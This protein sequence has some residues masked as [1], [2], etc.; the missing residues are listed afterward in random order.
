MSG[1]RAAWE[2]AVRLWEHCNRICCGI[3]SNPVVV[4]PV[5]SD[6]AWSAANSSAMF[7][8]DKDKNIRHR[9]ITPQK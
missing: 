4:T 5:R 8:R 6:V 7:V 2:K 1:P 9:A 3:C